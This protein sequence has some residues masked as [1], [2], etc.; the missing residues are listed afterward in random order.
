M[1][2]IPRTGHLHCMAVSASAASQRVLVVE[3]E[4][5][6]ARVMARTLRSRGFECDV[7]L[8]GAEAR[9]LIETQDYAIALLDVRLPDESGYGLLEEMRSVR[10]D[11]AV[12]MIS[13]VDDPELGTAALEHGA[14]A[15]HVKPVGATQLYLLVV[16]NIRRRSLEL[17]HRASL[18][19]LEGMVAERTEQMRRAAELQ[20]GML[21]AS[22]FKA[23]GFEIAAH[24]TAAREISGDF[25]DWYRSADR[26]VTATLGDVMGKG[27]PASLMMATAR[28]ALRGVAGVA[29]LD[30][31]VKQAAGVMS[32]ALEVNH[33][34]V[35]VFHCSFD[36]QSGELDY[37][38]AGHGHARILRGATAQELL[39]ERSAPIGIFPDTQF[40]TGKVSL[41]PGDSLVVFSDG[42]LE[43]RPDLAT[44]E[45]QLPY[46]VRRAQTAQEMVDILAQGARDQELFDDVTVLALKRI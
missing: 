46:E 38:D 2:R 44:K 3:D 24:F 6:L 26:R 1:L 32:A 37:V 33:A 4:E 7:A 36:P 29:P 45:V 16:N 34:Y 43:L 31:G 27:L 25:Y 14:Y 23:D 13:G 17:E 35:T 21:P 15:Y 40:V 5:P 10:P 19:R 30:S 28:A 12:V 41:R 20:S 22:P 11:T 9:K 8:S 18:D 42:L 39:G